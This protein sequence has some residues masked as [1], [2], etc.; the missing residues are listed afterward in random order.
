M[1]LEPVSGSGVFRQQGYQLYVNETCTRVLRVY[2][3]EKEHK[4]HPWS[5]WM[6]HDGL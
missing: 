4:I 5:V 2:L 6:D 1:Y 3:K